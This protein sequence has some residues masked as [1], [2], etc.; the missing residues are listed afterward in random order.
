MKKEIIP[1]EFSEQQA[2]EDIKK[3]EMLAAEDPGTHLYNLAWSYFFAG[4]NHKEH[5]RP[6]QAEELFLKEIGIREDL[7]ANNGAD[8]GYKADL[9]N[10][11]RFMG[12]FYNEQ[13]RP[14]EA[15]KCYLGAIEQSEKAA[16]ED[17]YHF[18]YDLGW[19]CFSAGEF[20]RDQGEPDKSE[21][22]INRAK[23]IR[24]IYEREHPECLED[25]ED[26]EDERSPQPPR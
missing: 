15:E 6:A 18:L 9:A 7:A 26:R 23:E 25:E 12:D 19:C 8:C 21:Y 22:Y 2:L 17:P 5:G 24:E 4:C 11:L 14:E 3:Y 10:S 1:E 16:A 13:R 20:Y